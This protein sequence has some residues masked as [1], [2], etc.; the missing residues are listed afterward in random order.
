MMLSS[1][2]FR[3]SPLEAEEGSPGLDAG[4]ALLFGLWTELALAGLLGG[5]TRGGGGALSPPMEST[6]FPRK[7]IVRLEL[8]VV[9]LKNRSPLMIRECWSIHA[10]TKSGSRT[11]TRRL[12]RLSRGREVRCTDGNLTP[13]IWAYRQ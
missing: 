2:A 5:F 4:L 11:C 3:F 6:M 7:L 8:E 10:V 13:G 12:K 9:T 1:S